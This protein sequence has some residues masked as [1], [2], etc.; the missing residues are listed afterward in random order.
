MQS[1]TNV[2]SSSQPKMGSTFMDYKT[3]VFNA[4]LEG[5]LMGLKVSVLLIYCREVI[6]NVAEVYPNNC[7]HPRTCVVLKSG[8]ATNVVFIILC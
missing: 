2:K 7:R 6:A 1:P 5:N 3:H 8:C 4:A